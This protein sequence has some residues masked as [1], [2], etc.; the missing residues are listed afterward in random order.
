LTR[1]SNSYHKKPLDL[2]AAFCLPKKIGYANL[3]LVYLFKKLY[4]LHLVEW[5][6]LIL[7]FIY[8]PFFSQKS[9]IIKPWLELLFLA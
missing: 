2:L 9:L 3:N 8:W 1:L 7:I 6:S 4:Q 5:L